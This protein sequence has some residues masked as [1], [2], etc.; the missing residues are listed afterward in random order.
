M[1]V[2]TRDYRP[3]DEEQVVSLS[4]R[5]WAPVFASMESAIGSEL[6][7]RLRGDWRVSQ[8][9]AVRKALAAPEQRVWVAVTEDGVVGFVVAILH[10]EGLVGE[11]WMLAVDPDA[12]DQGV[13]T[14]LTE[15][16]TEWLRTSGMRV[17]MV[18][19]GGDPGHAP[20]RRVYEKA[21][22]TAMPVSS[23]GQ[24]NTCLIGEH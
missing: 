7:A 12:Q 22:Y 14:N 3:S 15:V 6:F 1:S 4:L 5:A 21:D 11:I 17:A 18:D 2:L 9:E 19:T 23:S 10:S 20:A 13:G 16:A 8:E 24:R